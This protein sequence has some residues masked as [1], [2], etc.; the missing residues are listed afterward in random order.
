M[1]AARVAIVR[2]RSRDRSSDFISSLTAC[3]I[4]PSFF[5]TG[6]NAST[7]THAHGALEVMFYE[8]CH[9]TATMGA[10]A[11]EIRRARREPD[12]ATYSRRHR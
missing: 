1:L 5:T 10:Q 7:G 11:S 6:E 12:L 2:R 8:W 9:G 4:H 3:L